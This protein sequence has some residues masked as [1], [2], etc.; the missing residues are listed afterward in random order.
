MENLERQRADN[1]RNKVQN[2]EIGAVEGKGGG[3]TKINGARE[4]ADIAV[5]CSGPMNGAD[6]TVGLHNSWMGSR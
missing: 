4:G 5:G 1:A 6:D 2:G 3:G